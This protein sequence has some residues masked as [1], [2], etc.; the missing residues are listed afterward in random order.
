ML[1]LLQ[2]K[3]VDDPIWPVVTKLLDKLVVDEMV[4][5]SVPSPNY[6]NKLADE[7]LKKTNY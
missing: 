6:L 5:V 1:I 7:D 2:D 3:L 4:K